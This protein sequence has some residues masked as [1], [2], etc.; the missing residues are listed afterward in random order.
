MNQTR[1]LPTQTPHIPYVIVIH[2]LVHSDLPKRT[3]EI[4]AH[5]SM[6][7]S[8]STSAYAKHLAMAATVDSSDSN[9]FLI[10]HWSTITI[11]Y[12][13][14]DFTCITRCFVT[15]KVERCCGRASTRSRRCPVWLVSGLTCTRKTHDLV[16]FILCALWLDLGSGF[17]LRKFK[18]EINC[19]ICMNSA[20][21]LGTF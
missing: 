19:A 21:R 11:A 16:S 9:P 10:S 6:T 20:L 17:W 12:K 18:F 15:R 14:H 3:D 13:M 2:Q 4:D 8:G 5:L 7:A 1:H